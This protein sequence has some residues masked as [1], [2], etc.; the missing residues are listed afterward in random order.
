[1]SRIILDCELMKFPH[2]GLYQYCQNLG[3]HVNKL[4]AEENQPFMQM[5]IPP[6]K[7]LTLPW[8]PYHLVEQ[9]WHKLVKPFLRSCQVWHAPFQ[10]GRI[11][12]NK[13]LYPAIKVVL[14]IHDLNMLHE[15]KSDTY[16]QKSL[17]RTQ[18]LINRSDAIVCISEFTKG[19]VLSHCS[20]G[21]K[22]I[23]VIYNGLNKKTASVDKP[24]AYKPDRA[25]LL[26][27][28]YLNSKKNYHVLLPLLQA[29]P[30]LEM[31]ILGRHDDPQYVTMMHETAQKMGVEN[32]L[33]LPGT[34]SED[35]KIWY[36]KNCNAFLHPSLAEGFGLPVIEAMQFGK[37]VFLSRLTSLPEVG[38]DAAF[39]FPDFD[40]STVQAVYQ[41]GMQAYKLS[42]MANSIIEHAN[43]FSWDKTARQYLEVYQSLIG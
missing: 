41:Q 39:Y 19:D 13:R 21:N 22:P 25:F 34:V 4:L 6:R 1:M 9:K 12:P 7:K 2:S 24:V 27:I 17:A 38:G 40:A 18:S 3:E 26:G 35:D 31:I 28:G 32:R 29:N 37:P 20:V 23:H 8:E 36:L 30:D 42:N 33:H 11:V 14:T 15:G 16:Q 43:R 5:Y 10:S